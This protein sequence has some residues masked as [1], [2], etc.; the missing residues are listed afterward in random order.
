[1]LYNTLSERKTHFFC[2]LVINSAQK[3]HFG[4]IFFFRFTQNQVLNAI[5]CIKSLFDAFGA[6]FDEVAVVCL[7]RQVRDVRFL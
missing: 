4:G 3:A 6:F 5:G 7:H 1:M 2:E